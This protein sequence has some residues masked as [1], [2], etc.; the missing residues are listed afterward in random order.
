MLCNVPL[1]FFGVFNLV[2]CF[3]VSVFNPLR[4]LYFP[5][6]DLDASI[7]NNEEER[8]R[9]GIFSKKCDSMEK[10]YKSAELNTY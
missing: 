8:R 9:P 3:F 1:I 7:C 2:A 6:Q 5:L 10:M 4:L